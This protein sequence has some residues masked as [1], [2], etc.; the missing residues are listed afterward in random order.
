MHIE[1]DINISLIYFSNFKN[2]IR[3][4]QNKSTL[5]NIETSKKLKINK[6]FLINKKL[7][8]IISRSMNK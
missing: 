4:L 1:S 3:K 7:H 2:Y 5:K 8:R 6:Y